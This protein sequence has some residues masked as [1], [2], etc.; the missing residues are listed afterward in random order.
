MNK[1]ISFK[2]SLRKLINHFWILGKI[3]IPFKMI[4][5]FIFRYLVSD[6]FYYEEKFSETMGYYFDF[7]NPQTLNEKI[8]LLKLYDRS[9][10]HTQCAD[11]IN[12]RKYVSEVIGD[13]VLVPV[14]LSTKN[15]N[16]INKNTLPNY[17]FIIKATHDSGS[18][19][20]INDKNTHDFSLIRSEIRHWLKRNYYNYSKEYIIWSVE[21]SLKDLHTP[22]LDLLLLHRPSP[23]MHPNEI[24]AAVSVLKE[25]GKILDFGVS[26]FSP[27]QLSLLDNKTAVSV[28]QIEFSLTQHSAMHNGVLDQLLQKEVILLG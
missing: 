9:D 16:D 28:N 6:K 22:Y 15:V 24:A 10:L 20:I 1:L 23:L 21:K 5:H 4:Y 27:S 19:L 8:Q 26:N 3:I 2:S 18:T 13:K 25:S 11:K 14:F 7:K 17:P 12:V